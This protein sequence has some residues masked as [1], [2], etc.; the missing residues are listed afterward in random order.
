MPALPEVLRAQI[1]VHGPMDIATWMRLCLTH[2]EHGYYATQDPLGAGGDFTTAP[3]IS[4]LFGEMIGFWLADLWQQMGRP[5]RW[6]VVEFGPGRGTLMA[7]ALRIL[8][9]MPG[10]APT[11]HLVEVGQKLRA[12][13]AEK[14]AAYAPHWHDDAQTLPIDAPTLIISNE[15]FDALPVRQF[16]KTAAGWDEVVIGLDP[17]GDFCFGRVPRNDSDSPDAQTVPLGAVI[18]ISPARQGVLW[19]MTHHIR[20]M[21]GA[22]LAIDYG[23]AAA[24]LTSTLQAVRGHARADFLQA[25]GQVDLTALVDFAGLAA[26]AGA[27]MRVWGPVT[28]GAFLQNL[29]I[30]PRAEKVMANATPAQ[31]AEISAGLRRLTAPAEMGELF[32]VMAITPQQAIYNPAGFAV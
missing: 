29:G 5:A 26:G 23:Y 13:Q 31:R 22:I 21:G 15:F 9:R 11:L 28:Q 3:E 32:K 12:A 10:C 30:G 7:D 27:D 24:P 20:Q 4:Q 19:A 18:E 2:P 8:S 1:D 16:I 25:P 6:H 17:K 14:L